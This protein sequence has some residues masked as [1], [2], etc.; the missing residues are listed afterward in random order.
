MNHSKYSL[1]YVCCLRQYW[2]VIVSALTFP[3]R[4]KW[5]KFFRWKVYDVT[6]YARAGEWRSD[7]PFARQIMYARKLQGRQIARHPAK[8]IGRLGFEDKK[9]SRT[10][11]KV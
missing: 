2:S 9:F 6:L 4:K 8:E 1:Y 11:I 7:D 5:E 3:M 10:G